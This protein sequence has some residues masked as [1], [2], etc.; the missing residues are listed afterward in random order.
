V[1]VCVY[2]CVYVYMMYYMDVCLYICIYVLY[3]MYMKGNGNWKVNKA[4]LR[5]AVQFACVYVCMYIYI[6][7]LFGQEHMEMGICPGFAILFPAYIPIFLVYTRFDFLPKIE[8]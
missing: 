3:Y 8:K 2:V 7:T 4:A 6:H 1:Y 5:L